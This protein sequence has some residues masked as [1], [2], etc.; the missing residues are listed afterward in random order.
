V[1]KL[2]GAPVVN[3]FPNDYPAVNLAL[4]EGTALPA[5]SALGIAFAAFAE[6]LMGDKISHPAGHKRKFFEF[7]TVSPRPLAADRN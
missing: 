6:S 3:A 7:F 5:T 1:E 2:L 4:A